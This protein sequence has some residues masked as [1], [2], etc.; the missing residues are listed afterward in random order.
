MQKNIQGGKYFCIAGSLKR[1]QEYTVAAES[2]INAERMATT[3]VA[4]HEADGSSDGDM[5]NDARQ[6]S[7]RLH[8]RA[9]D[10]LSSISETLESSDVVILDSLGQENALGQNQLG[11]GG[12][13]YIYVTFCIL[14]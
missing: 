9:V 5:A 8:T 14:S 2:A 1:V 3:A 7:P 6:K 10:Q 4:L 12:S 13:I 11:I